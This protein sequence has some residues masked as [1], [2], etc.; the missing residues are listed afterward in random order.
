MLAKENPLL[1]FPEPG[2]F[3]ALL[4]PLHWISFLAVP[5]INLFLEKLQEY[6]SMYEGN[7]EHTCLIKHLYLILDV[8]KSVNPRHLNQLAIKVPF[9]HIPSQDVKFSLM[10]YIIFNMHHVT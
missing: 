6:F 4:I 9:N 2:Y 1:S 5:Q 10:Y 7:W 3:P 8:G